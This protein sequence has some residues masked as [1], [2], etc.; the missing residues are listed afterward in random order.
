MQRERCGKSS[1]I[2]ALNSK[3]LSYQCIYL[4]PHK[5]DP[6][7]K[8]SCHEQKSIADDF[9]RLGHSYQQSRVGH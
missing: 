5:T 7:L 4:R 3:N 8:I 6:E 9:G 2:M 1:A